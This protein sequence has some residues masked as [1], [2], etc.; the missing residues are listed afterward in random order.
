M[1]RYKCGCGRTYKYYNGL[2]DHIK[3]K[4]GGSP[5]KGSY[6]PRPIGRP[7]TKKKEDRWADFKIF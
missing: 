2:H 6:K 5:P 3:Q 1:R 4:H 7:K